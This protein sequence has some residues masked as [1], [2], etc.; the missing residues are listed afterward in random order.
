MSSKNLTFFAYLQNFVDSL[1]EV[2]PEHRNLF[3]AYSLY[4][5]DKNQDE[6]IAEFIKQLSKYKKQIMENDP[7]LF[8][9]DIY[10]LRGINFK[11]L[12]N[13][14]HITDASKKSIWDYLK[15]LF[16]LG[17]MT[18]ET[19]ENE[20]MTELHEQ[21]KKIA[22]ENKESEQGGETGFNPEK[23]MEAGTKVKEL[24]GNE[25]NVVSSLVEDITK[26]IGKEFGDKK[27]I[28]L[29]Q[30]IIK[31][32]NAIQRI[33]DNVK[34]TVDDKIARGEIKEDEMANSAEKVAGVLNSDDIQKKLFGGMDIQ[35]MFA[36]MSPAQMHQMQEMAKGIMPKQEPRVNP[37][38][39]EKKNAANQLKKN[40]S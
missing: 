19:P 13:D 27:N 24:F 4:I 34:K 1:N 11:L 10:L 23:L 29:A 14:K 18:N 37:K 30:L 3:D 12:W 22:E 5:A 31:D 33:V 32:K 26:E 35:K 21:L 9:N 40:R 8:E 39:Q 15:L 28:N 7:A 25:D 20:S 2:F 38:R 17:K 6:F 36:S 16:F